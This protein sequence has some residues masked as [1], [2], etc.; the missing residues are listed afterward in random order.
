VDKAIKK[1]AVV[2]R[3]A[4]AWIAAYILRASFAKAEKPVEVV[5]VELPS[6]LHPHEYYNVL[7]SH[8][9]LH[10][11]MGL[12][13]SLVYKTGGLYSL[14]QRFF[15]WSGANTSFFHG[16]DTHGVPINKIE[17][18]H[19]WVKACKQ[20]QLDL[21]LEAFSF[22]V[23]AAK[24]GRFISLSETAAEISRATYGYHLNALSYVRAIAKAAIGLGVEHKLDEIKAVDVLNGV[25]KSI[26]LLSGSKIQADLYIDASGVDAVLLSQLEETDN[27]ESW[28]HWLPCDKKITTSLPP[29]SPA[30]GFAQMV[31]FDNGWM[32]YFPLL[33]RTAL[34]AV[35][36]SQA[37]TL[38]Q[39]LNNINKISGTNI[40]P[41]S[42]VESTIK[43]GARKKSWVG[44]C[45]AIGDAAGSIE[46]L[47]A[48][49]LHT[50]HL[51]L[52]LLRSLFPNNQDSMPEAG[53]YNDKIQ[54]Y[55]NNIRD[56]TIAH[57][58]MNKRKGEILWDTC[59]EMP[60][61]ES[62]QE[63]ISLFASR[64]LVA[65]HEEETFQEENWTSILVGHELM[66]ET[67]DPLVDKIHVSDLVQ[68]FEKILQ[69][70]TGEVS[71]MPSMQSHIEINTDSSSFA[72]F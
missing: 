52:S 57:Y 11:V 5:L 14:G 18:L 46:P 31:A 2:G 41:N 60:V 49:Q 7:P 13:E 69:Y 22:V 59:R 29:L 39:T 27:F 55:L 70:I 51:S 4:E 71:S 63:K 36:S 61:P 53:I 62:L 16:Y 47:D 23:E 21:P 9:V 19:Y 68:Q 40:K 3:D 12:Q 54:A 42:V 24:Q 37:A 34:T 38:E 25:I 48:T 58:K 56:F 26:A 20:L 72:S 64:G 67:Y 66:P 35:Y 30:P 44:N 33:K 15:N 65:M 6:K 32:G 1:I 45:V 8:Q 28:T 10:K 43:A 17:F 50:L